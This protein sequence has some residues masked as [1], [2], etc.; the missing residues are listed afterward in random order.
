MSNGQQLSVRIV[1]HRTLLILILAISVY[2]VMIKVANSQEV[3][4]N[5][6][7]KFD[8]RIYYN[9]SLKPQT[10]I[11]NQTGLDGQK[12]DYDIFTEDII[13]YVSDKLAMEP[14]YDQPLLNAPAIT[15]EFSEKYITPPRKKRRSYHK[16]PES[17]L[18]QFE[19]FP[20]DNLS[21]QL[22]SPWLTMYIQREPNLKVLAKFNWHNRQFL[23]DQTLL[24]NPYLVYDFSP[25]ELTSK[26]YSAYADEYNKLLQIPNITRHEILAMNTNI[27]E[28]LLWLFDRIEMN[29]MTFLAGLGPRL[30]NHSATGYT[31]IV[32]HLVHQCFSAENNELQ[33][34]KTI[35]DLD[36]YEA[37]ELLEN[38][39]INSLRGRRKN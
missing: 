7:D 37:L 3:N 11:S 39:K 10:S 17:I 6:T 28:D 13:N 24:S 34:Y 14:G 36:S 16:K 2:G 22:S 20:K 27:P 15:L 32:K 33:S 5:V 30:E 31:S 26:T 12:S 4:V 25:Q 18:R 35:L 29:S 1:K 9:G 21:C 8:L 19:R 38:Y 23:I